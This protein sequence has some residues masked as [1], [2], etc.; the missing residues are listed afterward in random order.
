MLQF[1]K[2]TLYNEINLWVRFQ[3]YFSHI[4][5]HSDLA[6]LWKIRLKREQTFNQY[7]CQNFDN[8]N[9]W[10]F[11]FLLFFDTQQPIFLNVE[12]YYTVDGLL[13]WW[14]KSNML[15]C[16]VIL[17]KCSVKKFV[18][19]TSQTHAGSLQINYEIFI[20]YS[21]CIHLLFESFMIDSLGSHW[22]C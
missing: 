8:M 9:Y 22:R 11:V 4:W 17:W 20:T 15:S 16:A 1:P 12:P 14:R 13:K 21:L 2:L 7:L 18:N 10:G 6:L 3:D 5:E 19:E